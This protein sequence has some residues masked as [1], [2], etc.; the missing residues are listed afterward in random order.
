MS[1]ILIPY[2]RIIRVLL[3]I[4]F[5]LLILNF[6]PVGR[7]TALENI[8]DL[9]QEN[10]IPT[11]FSSLLLLAVAFASA[12]I[13]ALDRTKNYNSTWRFFWPLF[14]LV[15]C[16]L[17]LDEGSGLHETIS[18]VF[19]IKW[20]WIYYP[21]GIFFFFLCAYFLENVYK[22]KGLADFVLGGLAIF[23]L[24]VTTCEYLSYY[25][26]IG[27]AEAVIEKGFEMLGT[28]MVLNGCLKEANSHLSAFFNKKGI[29]GDIIPG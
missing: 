3:I 11:W 17:S 18:S 29:T 5:V 21:A 16:F 22:V 10:N 28:I 6:L 4:E 23:A 24:G 1:S 9:E 20:T 12:I 19:N 2:K 7:E 13:F 15:F 27:P 14:S 25:I 26:N 8:F